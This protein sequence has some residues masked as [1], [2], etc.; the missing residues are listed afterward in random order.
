MILQIEINEELARILEARAIEINSRFADDWTP[1][2]LAASM[3]AHVLV[4]DEATHSL[5]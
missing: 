2:T 4:D 3:L 5:Q 1:A